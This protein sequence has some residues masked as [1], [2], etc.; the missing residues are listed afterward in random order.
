MPAFSYEAITRHG[1]KQKGRIEAVNKAAAVSELKQSGV[2]VSS[3]MEEKQSVLQKEI[4]I[5]LF[6]PVKSQHFV[7]FLRQLATLIRA[8]VGIVDSVHI[9]SQQSESKELRRV[10]R[11]AAGDI[12]RGSQLSEA[13]AKH[14]KIFEP[15]FLSMLRAG[16]ASG[17]MEIVLDRMAT[18]YEKS[19]YTRE[20]IKSAMMYP[21][22]MMVLTVIVTIFLLTNIVPMFVNMFASFNAEL[23]AIT[24]TVLAV[25]DSLVST[26]YVYL[27]VLIGSVI[28]IRAI[29]RMPRGRYAFDYILLKIPV[30]GSLFQKGSLARVTRTLSTLFSS[31]VPVLQSLTIVENVAD[32]IV[33]SRAIAASKESL[34][35][36][37]PL[38]E[39]LK[40]SW[41][42][43]PLVTHMIAI[44][45]E[46]GSMDTMLEKIADFYEAEVEATV[47]R[48]KALIEPLMI[49]VLAVIIGAIV[50][51]IMV[52]MFEIFNQV[53]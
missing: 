22:V 51:S 27:L 16:E 17:S 7:V 41:V 6:R 18:F 13:C 5:H 45:E 37:R 48:V 39:P 12:Q 26:W 40:K 35:Q 9:L 25:S 47:D 43:P 36:G 15:L 11:E 23:P 19:H 2:Y 4:S 38:S 49:V 24:K 21:V 1:K 34:R 53:K 20:K 52:P 28:A 14:P 33:V 30:F 50:L 46:T 3:I 10:L 8:G 32:N 44:G 42:F 31:S 29:L